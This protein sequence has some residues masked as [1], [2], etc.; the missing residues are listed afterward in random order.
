[1]KEKE[2]IRKERLRIGL[3]ILIR[4]RELHMTQNELAEASGVS[5]TQISSMERGRTNFRME[6]LF[7]IAE[8]LG[9]EYQELIK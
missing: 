4:R 6:A 7:A 1:M 8:A 2:L 5:R 3:N 9:V